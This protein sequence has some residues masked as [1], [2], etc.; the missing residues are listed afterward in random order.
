MKRCKSDEIVK[1]AA[2][3][4]VRVFANPSAVLRIVILASFGLMVPGFL[5]AMIQHGPVLLPGPSTTPLSDVW[6]IS[7]APAGLLAMSVGLLL[8]LV[9]PS[10]RVLLGLEDF[11][12]RREIISVVAALIVLAELIISIFV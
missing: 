4:F 12:R 6:H 11:V 1:V 7:S 3:R 2:R 9:I 5:D 8:F 10:L